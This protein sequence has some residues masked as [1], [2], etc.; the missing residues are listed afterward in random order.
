MKCN[1]CGNEVPNGYKFCPNC[2]NEIIEAPKENNQ[3]T[4]PTSK[5]K[6]SHTK[7]LVIIII[8]LVLIVGLLIGFIMFGDN[9]FN[10]NEPTTTETSKK[11]SN[12]NKENSQE[13]NN[14][15][16]SNNDKESNNNG[17]NTPETERPNNNNTNIPEEEFNHNAKQT[18][19]T[20]D[21]D[22]NEAKVTF[23]ANS[24]NEITKIK[25]EMAIPYSTLGVSYNDLMSDSSLKSQLIQSL[26]NQIT[27]ATVT[28]DITE[29]NVKI[30]M[31]IDLDN[32]SEETLESLGFDGTENKDLDYVIQNA[33]NSGAVCR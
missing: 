19:C 7:L 27:G 28:A 2:G 26:S 14:K 1:K 25:M 21:I 9:L 24:N 8:I 10:D 13:N 32:A 17:E 6:K 22:D 3:V 11:S 30:T 18:T 16:D 29:E 23:N 4:L 12:K 5:S 15:E 31:E 33:R 20:M